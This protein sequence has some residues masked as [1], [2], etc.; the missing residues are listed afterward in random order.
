MRSN[1]V[2]LL[3]EVKSSQHAALQSLQAEV[4][5]KMTQDEGRARQDCREHYIEIVVVK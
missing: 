4:K 1:A 3:S 5:T 2:R